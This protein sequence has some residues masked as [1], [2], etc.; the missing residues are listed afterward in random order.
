[1]SKFD[2][3]YEQILNE[4]NIEDRN[5]PSFYDYAVLFVKQLLQ[6]N[7]IDPKDFDVRKTA[8]QIVKDS[9]YNF[10]DPE[11]N[12]SYKVSFNFN[13]GNNT[14]NA[15]AVQIKELPSGKVV[16]TIDNT[17]E[18]SSIEDIVSFIETKKQ[19]AQSAGTSAPEQVSDTQSEMPGAVKTQEPN[20]SQ[21]LKGL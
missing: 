19:E 15:L 2:A 14:P 10:I 7:L 6:H 1:M 8:E 4:F 18:E 17:F 9:Y 5:D 20:T 12:V 13:S 3:L 11:D 16:Q 21:Y